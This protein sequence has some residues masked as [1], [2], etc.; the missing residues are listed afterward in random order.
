VIV[1]FAQDLNQQSS[2]QESLDQNKV[3][4]QLGQDI[5]RISERFEEFRK[6]S[7]RIITRTGTLQDAIPQ[8]QAGL[9]FLSELVKTL[10]HSLTSMQAMLRHLEPWSVTVETQQNILV[11]SQSERYTMQWERAVHDEI[12]GLSSQE[13]QSIKNIHQLQQSFAST[14]QPEEE[15]FGDNVELF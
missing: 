9:V 6:T 15:S 8:P 4:Q 2:L 13:T 3:A 1:S 10:N 7:S 11:N 14:S 5:E 12:L